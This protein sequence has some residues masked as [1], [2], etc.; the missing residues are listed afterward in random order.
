MVEYICLF[1]TLKPQKFIFIEADNQRQAAGIACR[2]FGVTGGRLNPAT[3]YI[4]H[5]KGFWLISILKTAL[6]KPWWIQDKR[7]QLK[8]QST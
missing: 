5:P 3:G 6:A 7:E 2:T 8:S 4:E 1:D